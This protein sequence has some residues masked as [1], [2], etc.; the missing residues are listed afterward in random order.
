MLEW[1]AFYRPHSVHSARAAA[2]TH[3]GTQTLPVTMLLWL[4]Y[5]PPPNGHWILDA[6]H[7]PNSALTDR[8]LHP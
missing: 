4:F 6:S 2:I 7:R 5:A 8:S 3:N 1:R